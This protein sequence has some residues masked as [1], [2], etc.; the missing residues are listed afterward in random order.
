[1]CEK[2]YL[3]GSVFRLGL[4]KRPLQMC[5]TLQVCWRSRGKDFF[6]AHVQAGGFGARLQGLSEAAA[7]TA[8]LCRGCLY[9]RESWG[10]RAALADELFCPAIA[11]AVKDH[12]VTNLC[13]IHSCATSL[14]EEQGLAL[15]RTHSS[16]CTAGRIKTWQAAA[17]G[18]SMH[19]ECT[20]LYFD[21]MV[22]LI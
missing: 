13:S 3:F 5:K 2:Q 19:R 16:H 9:P 1:M 8:P 6:R 14:W 18:S 22:C 7:N 10:W 17:A 15:T 12:V 20:H 4:H 11:Q 21:C